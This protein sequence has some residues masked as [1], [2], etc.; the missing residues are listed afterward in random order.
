MKKLIVYG[1][2]LFIENF[3]IGCVLL[4]ITAEIFKVRFTVLKDKIRFV[5]GGVMCG[6]FSMEIF[7]PLPMY[8]TVISEIMFAFAVCFVVLG[9]ERI[10]KKA[11][12]M[13]LVT[14][15]MGGLTVGLLLI[16]QNPGIYTASG[17]YTGDMKAAFLALFIGMGTFTAKQIMKTVASRKFYEE[18][19]F[20]V[21]IFIG[22]EVFETKGFFDTGNQLTD[23]INGKPVAVAQESLWSRFEDE[24]AVSD[25][26]IGIVPYEAIGTKGIMMSLRVDFIEIS[27]R[28]LRGN[29]IAKGSREFN[30]YGKAA[31]GCELLL[32][33]DMS[34][35][36][37]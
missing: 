18:H 17:I 12:T 19:V 23:P 2:I 34:D 30:I 25:D 24:G 1:E 9:K 5:L 8:F 22:D 4:Y 3:V 35:R 20:D 37:T 33:K 27:G 21:K 13:I 7:L 11:L 36:K 6:I 15:F 26:R 28:R 29:V 14:Y 10:W 32:S 16:T 31:N